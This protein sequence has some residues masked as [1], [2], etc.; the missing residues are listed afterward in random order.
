MSGCRASYA[1]EEIEISTPD[2]DEMLDI[3]WRS[4]KALVDFFDLLNQGNYEKA[5]ALYG[6]SYDMLQGYNPEA[7]PMDESGLLAAG[8]QANG[9]MCLSVLNA[10]LTQ[11]NN[12]KE[13][14]Y[15]VSYRNPDGTEFVLGPCCGASEE[16]MPPVSTFTV[17]VVCDTWDSCQVM[18][19]PPY[20]P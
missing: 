1:S 2:A 5:A 16:E 20:V 9:L 19:L 11:I 12:Q 14:N 3:E 18:D 10:T 15:D 8:C 13:F 4:K 7:D 17:H 6:G